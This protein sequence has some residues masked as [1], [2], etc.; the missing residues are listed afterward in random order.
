MELLL[1][2]SGYIKMQTMKSLIKIISDFYWSCLYQGTFNEACSLFTSIFIEFAKLCIPSKTIVVLED[3]KPLYNSE[4]RRNSSKRDR[5]KQ[6]TL[7]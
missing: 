3:D 4:I 1:E 5:L 6:T 7:K 2:M